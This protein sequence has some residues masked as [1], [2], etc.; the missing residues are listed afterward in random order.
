MLYR[1]NVGDATQLY[2]IQRKKI[3]EIVM[4]NV[5][6]QKNYYKN[7]AFTGEVTI[8]KQDIKEDES[9]MYSKIK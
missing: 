2:N 8:E 9:I 6:K 7:I 4:Q 5:V 1:K 3:L